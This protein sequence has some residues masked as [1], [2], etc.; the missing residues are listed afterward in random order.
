MSRRVVCTFT[1]TAFLCLTS[2]CYYFFQLSQQETGRV[3]LEPAFV[4]IARNPQDGDVVEVHLMLSNKSNRVIRV[5]NTDTSCGCTRLN[6]RGNVPLNLPFEIASGEAIP[7][8]AS[9]KTAGRL[10]SSMVAVS[11]AVQ[12]GNSIIDLQSN[13]QMNVDLEWGIALLIGLSRT[14]QLTLTLKRVF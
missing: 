6:T 13:I 9:I 2:A 10:G 3:R 5:I 7:L 4:E 1:V 14:N 11:V 8:Q 12:D